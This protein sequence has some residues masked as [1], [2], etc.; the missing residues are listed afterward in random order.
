MLGDMHYS[1]HSGFT[2]EQFKYAIHEQMQAPK[3]RELYTQT[4][5]T[6]LI[7]DHDVG[8]KNADSRHHSVARAT[9]GFKQIVPN[10]L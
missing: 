10:D 1:G 5:M 8:I 2:A 6:Y 3:I 7:D 4:P 9:K